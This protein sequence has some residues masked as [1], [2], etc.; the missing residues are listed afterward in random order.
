MKT[1]IQLQKDVLDELQF[2]PTVDAAEIGVTTRDGIVT[3]TGNVKNYAE[4]WGAGRAAERV[5]GA[6]AVIDK[7]EVKLPEQSRRSDEAIARM[8][9]DMLKWD[10]MVPDE[11]IKVKV[12]D[13]WVTL[14]GTVDYKHEQQSAESAIRNL[15]GVKGVNNL[16]QVKPKL[17]ATDVKAKIENALRRAAELEAQQIHVD[18]QGKKVVLTGTVHSWAERAE[19][20]RAAWSAPGVAQV[21]DDLKVA[22]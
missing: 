1:D 10:V 8:A 16:V 11:R 2:E 5:S 7:L 4:K 20:E 17:T 15:T 3:L 22:A 12:G 9:L 13:G 19:A 18:V 6:K 14:E 21:E